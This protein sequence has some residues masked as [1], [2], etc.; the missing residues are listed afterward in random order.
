MLSKI[1]STSAV[2]LASSTLVS[3]QTFSACNPVKGDSKL[4]APAPLPPFV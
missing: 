2:L 3:A 1:L 4:I